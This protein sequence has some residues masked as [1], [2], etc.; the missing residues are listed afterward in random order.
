MFLVDYFCRFEPKYLQ[1]DGW[2][3]EEDFLNAVD[4]F[5]LLAY[6]R[7]DSSQNLIREN[8]VLALDGG[9]Y[10]FNLLAYPRWDT[11]QNL[12]RENTVLALDGGR[13]HFNLLAYPRWH[14]SQRE[15]CTST[16]WR[17]VL[18][19]PAGIPKMGYLT[20]PHFREHCTSTRRRY[21]SFLDTDTL[22]TG[23]LTG[24]HRGEQS[25]GLEV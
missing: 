5:N 9:M 25:I 2:K 10:H 23:H 1:G 11:L 8:T 3:V 14:A 6:P 21:V 20:E 19:Q 4:H 7:W 18:L 22:K 12:I 17:Y 15:H 24:P 13:Y 16:R